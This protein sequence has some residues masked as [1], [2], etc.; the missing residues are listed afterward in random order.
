MTD[1]L[2][3]YELGK[4]LAV[5]GQGLLRIAKRKSDGLEVVI[6]KYSQMEDATSWNSLEEGEVGA[7]REISFLERANSDGVNG[8]PYLLEHGI[9]GGFGEPIAV[10]KKIPGKTLREKVLEPGYNSS[11]DY[12]NW[13]V[14]SVKDVLEYAHHSNGTKPVIHRDV[15]PENIMVNGESVTVMDWATST[16]TSGKTQFRTQFITQYYTAPEIIN[17]EPFDRRADIYSLGKVLQFMLLGSVFNEAEGKPAKMDFDGLNVPK[18]I[19]NVLDKATQEKPENRYR[20]VSDFYDAFKKALGRNLPVKINENQ[21]K[22]SAQT[23][24]EPLPS[25]SRK[26]TYLSLPS[27]QPIEKFESLKGKLG[28]E[29]M[30][31]LNEKVEEYG[32]LE[33]LKTLK[34]KRMPTRGFLEGIV[35]GGNSFTR[36]LGAEVLREMGLIAATRPDLEKMFGR[37][38]RLFL[39][40]VDVG[41]ALR[42][43]GDSY[44][45]NDSLAK[46]LYGDLNQSGIDV[47][48]GGGKLVSFN[49]LSLDRSTSSPYGV[50]F[51]FNG[52][53]AQDDIL[54]LS[55]FKWDCSRNDGLSQAGFGRGLGEYWDSSLEFLAS[56][57][58]AGRVVAV[59]AEGTV[60]KK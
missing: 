21:Y 40:Y 53:A 60:P 23:Q 11:L 38:F 4:P 45:K 41:V 49:A 51:R 33:V 36:V 37:N 46:T 32:N 56:S 17:G 3:G 9:A 12:V 57:A 25:T 26:I 10:F 58:G 31:R 19:V 7:A 18:N 15:S 30:E 8:I 22:L 29:F 42:T 14:K 16:P 43:N 44:A 6:K 54:D 35:K 28:R 47:E 1:I 59:R 34:Y 20:N 52:K 27:T 48:S 24:E 50:V 13:V 2:D 39:N 55:S 5:G